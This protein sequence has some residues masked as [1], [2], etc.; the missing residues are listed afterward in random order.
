MPLDQRIVILSIINDY[1]QDAIQQVLSRKWEV[2]ATVADRPA[3]EITP[4]ETTKI[5]L[6][7]RIFTIRWNEEIAPGGSLS[8][9]NYAVDAAIWRA[10]LA[11]N[12]N[13]DEARLI[14]DGVV[15][16]V[17]RLTTA[18]VN[19]ARG[20]RRFLTIEAELMPF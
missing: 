20:R 13:V 8:S 3:H 17:W 10:A 12:P 11:A 2:W 18:R 4:P 5:Y 6:A 16:P 7:E 15:R 9:D 14:I 19:N 1:V